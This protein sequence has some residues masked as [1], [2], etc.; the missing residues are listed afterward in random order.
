MNNFFRNKKIIFI[1]ILIFL[2]MLYVVVNKSI[3]K[4]D[5]NIITEESITENK[6][7]EE[8]NYQYSEDEI[9]V[10]KRGRNYKRNIHPKNTDIVTYKKST[11][12]EALIGY[13]YLK[14]KKRLNDILEFIEVK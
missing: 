5:K 9:D 10:V 4:S 14:D 2:C 11:G 13:L 3:N 7:D 12:F 6:N 1:S 8:K